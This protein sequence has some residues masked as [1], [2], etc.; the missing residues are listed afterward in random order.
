MN[1]PT[2]TVPDMR[3]DKISKSAEKLSK[4]ALE[5]GKATAERLTHKEAKKKRRRTRFLL[6]R[7]P[8]LAGVALAL[9]WLTDPVSGAERRQR[10]MGLVGRR[11]DD[12]VRGEGSMA[13]DRTAEPFVPTQP[14][15]M[16]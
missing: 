4:A 13:F 2:L 3:V 10:L 9:R 12:Q 7:L 8:L 16:E 14:P 11:H 1:T 5:A 15:M 6:T